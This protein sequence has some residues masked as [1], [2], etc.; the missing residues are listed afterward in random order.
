[1]ILLVCHAIPHN[2]EAHLVGLPPGMHYVVYTLLIA[3]K[4]MIMPFSY[5]NCS[6]H[7]SSMIRF[8][9][10]GTHRHSSV[11][12]TF[13][14]FMLANMHQKL[15]PIQGQHAIGSSILCQLTFMHIH[16]IEKPAV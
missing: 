10:Y 7:I 2:H 13:A 11:N 5:T 4:Y 8:C 3:G 12:K 1:M 16:N 14:D 15:C 9:N 6:M